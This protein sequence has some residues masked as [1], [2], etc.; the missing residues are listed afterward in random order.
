MFINLT[1]APLNDLAVRQARPSPTGWTARAIPAIGE[2]GVRASLQPGLHR[3]P[4]L[5]FVARY[6][7][8]VQVQLH[9]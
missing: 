2:Y 8:F 5:Q 6:V 9:L 4:H 7:P 3:H 1:V